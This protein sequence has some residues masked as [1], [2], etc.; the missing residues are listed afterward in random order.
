MR[1]VYKTAWGKRVEVEY[2]DWETAIEAGWDIYNGQLPFKVFAAI[3]VGAVD[4]LCDATKKT[5][6]LICP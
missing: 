5:A 4:G 3:L 2:P 6:K 1:V